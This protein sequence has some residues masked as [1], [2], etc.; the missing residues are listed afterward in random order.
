M[1]QSKNQ[2]VALVTGAAGFIGFHV[3]QVAA[4][5]MESNWSRL[6]VDY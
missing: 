3:E 1:V 5:W 4:R 2:R 6:Y